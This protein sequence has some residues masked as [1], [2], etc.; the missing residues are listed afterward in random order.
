VSGSALA[1]GSDVRHHEFERPR[2][3]TGS[4]Y[5]VCLKQTAEARQYDQRID[6]ATGRR[7]ERVA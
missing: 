7:P 4:L 3:Q 6:P 5:V 2:Q 1:V